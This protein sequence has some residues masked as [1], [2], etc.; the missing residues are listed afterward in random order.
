MK[1]IAIASAAA[2]AVAGI[3]S[4][5]F[6]TEPD[7]LE[8]AI[9]GTV[10]ELC[11]LTSLTSTA[12]TIEVDFGVLSNTDSQI[13]EDVPFGVVC[14]SAAGATL[15]MSSANGGK[16]L[17]GGTETGPGN[18]IAY[19]VNPDP[20]SDSFS[21]TPGTPPTSLSVTKSYNIAAGT[22]LREG[23]PFDVAIFFDGVKGPDFQ[24]APTTTVFAGDYSDTITVALV[25]N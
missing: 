13:R 10:E 25:A 1:K 19:K 17:R 7:D 18:E 3:A 22:A 4:A 20:G 12:G 11:G 8:I 5:E 15:S 6:I 23:R 21:T 9:E 16:L 2:I 24:G 14:N